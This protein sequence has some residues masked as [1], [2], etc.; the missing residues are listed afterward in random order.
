M[1]GDSMIGAYQDC[2]EG[3][4]SPWDILRACQA[5]SKHPSNLLLK[6]FKKNLPYFFKPKFAFPI[7]AKISNLVVSSQCTHCPS[8]E[9]C[10]PLCQ[11]SPLF[12]HD[13]T[14]KTKLNFFFLKV[15]SIPMPMF[16]ALFAL[17]QNVTFVTWT[18]YNYSLNLTK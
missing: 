17:S 10:C 15:V 9:P 3:H 14:P 7:Q 18:L 12:I 1:D 4:P 2:H 6:K 13:E 5:I 16:L 8:L 11:D